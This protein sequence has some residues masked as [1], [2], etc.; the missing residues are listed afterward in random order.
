MPDAPKY[1]RRTPE[2]SVLYRVV[3]QNLET[4]LAEAEEAG[5]VVPRFVER[6]L[7]AF[8]DCGILARGF[9]RVR[10]KACGD[11]RLVAF[12]CKGRGFCP[13][14]TSRR[15]SDTAAHLVDRVFP[16]AP[17]R[18]W[19][20]SPI[21]L[22]YRLAYDHEL[23]ST[24]LAVF[25]RAVFG[26][27][28]RR[29]KNELGVVEG[30]GGSVT[31]VQRFGGSINIHTHFHALVL[32]GVYADPEDT[33]TP[34]FFELPPPSD[35]EVARVTALVAKR[36]VR[37]LMRRGLLEEDG[38]PREDPLAQEEPL[39]AAC[40]EASVRH[41]IATGVRAGMLVMRL[42][43]RIEIEDVESRVGEQCA[44]VQGF[45]LHAGVV[46]GG[47]DRKRI[48]RLSRYISR[49]PIARE[50]LHELSDG[51]IAYRLRHPWRDGTTHVVFESTELF[52]NR[53][54]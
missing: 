48:E 34:R 31:F 29:A 40:A 32:D 21:P 27:L 52:E 4:F 36:I 7:R 38:P 42:G 35:E 53:A 37:L 45:S 17:V 11:D 5:R 49:P 23:C 18:Q 14:C 43:D 50:R 6:E 28:R 12:S 22:R 30:R 10:C 3:Q 26:A 25:L 54:S 16:E 20:L 47:R 51:R 44:S 8:L 24:V 1:Q 46:I 39:L 2:S 19:V 33:G 15:M 13:S 9:L 41:R